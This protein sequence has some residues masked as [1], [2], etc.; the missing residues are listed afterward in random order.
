MSHFSVFRA[1]L[2]KA[3]HTPPRSSPGPGGTRNLPPDAHPLS[4]G[5]TR[6]LF[7]NAQP[8]RETFSLTSFGCLLMLIH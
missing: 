6:N 7:S 3:P 1:R 8:S 2:C 4:P 5:G